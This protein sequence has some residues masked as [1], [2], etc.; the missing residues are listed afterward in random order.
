MSILGLV[1]N[2]QHNWLRTYSAWVDG[3]ACL[4]LSGIWTCVL[5]ILL[6]RAYDSISSAI[7]SGLGV[8]A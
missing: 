8:L 2:H 4:R 3:E 1:I 7:Y 5:K 6:A